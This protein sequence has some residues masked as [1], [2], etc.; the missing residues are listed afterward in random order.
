M[1]G[2]ASGMLKGLWALPPVGLALLLGGA[3]LLAGAGTSAAPLML[4]LLAVPA[5][6]YVAVALGSR[7]RTPEDLLVADR[8]VGALPNGLAT[9]ADWVSAAMFV[10]LAGTL[11][12]Q[13]S[14]G[15]AFL[16]GWAGGL[17]LAALAI[18]PG[19]RRSGAASVPDFLAGRFGGSVVRVAA[20]TVLAWCSFAFLMAQL[21]GA[22]AV[23]T[24]FLGLPFG[25]AVWLG[26]L[27]VL[28][29]TLPGGLRSV[30]WTQVAQFAAI[31]TAYLV[32][33]AV[34]SAAAPEG[35]IPL[36]EVMTG[37]AE[38]GGRTP[39]NF[40][41]LALALALG[42]AALP[43]LLQ[44]FLAAPSAGSARRAGGWA[45]LFV[46]AIYL[47][48]PLYAA[49]ARSEI[50]GSV[51]GARVDSL[52]GA[53]ALP[54][55]VYEYGRLGMVSV[56]GKLPTTAG[57]VLDACRSAHG[58]ASNPAPLAAGDVTIHPDLVVMAAPDMAGLPPVFGVLLAAGALAAALSTASG[59]V[60]TLGAA[61][62]HDVWFRLLDP[63]APA[64]RRVR[65]L[66]LS[67]AGLTA[68]AAYA[69]AGAPFAMLTLVAWSFSLAAAGLL[70]ALLL[71]LWWRRA[72]AAGAVAG[73]VTGFGTALWYLIRTEMLGAA[74][75]LGIDGIAAGAFGVPAGL[76][77][78]V[79]VSLLTERGAEVRAQHGGA[80]AP[81][82]P[83]A[84]RI[85]AE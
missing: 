42:T 84:A 60:A 83:G 30:T 76:L 52:D 2:R 71:G 62:G 74:P 6:V 78:A 36:A 80:D 55:W 18:A 58:G 67:M 39:L 57:A 37:A 12:V 59:L 82:R 20:V 26:A 68:L 77:A 11:Y 33:A 40:I 85:P 19:L 50:Q 13:G 43:H 61:A 16:L 44:R 29:C 25:A 56:C 65:A 46:V 63:R 79:A 64:A 72:T 28:A 34:I 54:R 41:S 48:A 4:A 31:A 27:L 81:G 45:L 70:P 24:R 7:G 21:A 10:G 47:T 5:L 15:L 17:A 73:M 38:S 3:V 53:R 49:F 23:A 1:P 9:A 22:A 51:V 14:S 35:A 32:P 8:R 66:R 75:L 69:T